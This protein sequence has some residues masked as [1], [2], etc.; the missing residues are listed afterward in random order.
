M[1]QI[2]F[3]TNESITK[4]NP[5]AFE[6][7]QFVQKMTE[8]YYSYL[9]AMTIASDPRASALIPEVEAGQIVSVGRITKNG[10]T[11]HTYDFLHHL[12]LV[13]NDIFIEEHLKHIWI[14][15]ALLK[16]GDALSCYGYFDR[17]PE[18]ELV[19]HLRN[20]IAHGNIFRIDNPKNLIKFPAH[21]KIAWVRNETKS[22]FVIDE[23][24]NGLP[25]LFEFMSEAD[26]LELFMSVSIYL[27]GMG[28]GDQMRPQYE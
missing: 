12:N 20:G 5:R 17:A 2:L 28:N 24:L 14:S 19:R 1:T 9:A 6:L 16:I 21:N 25:V 22:D 15:G 18:L 3:P 10:K 7:G 8:G 13:K 26:V 23:N 4:V 27:I 11:Q